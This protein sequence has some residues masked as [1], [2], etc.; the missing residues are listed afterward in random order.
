MA[1]A[2]LICGLTG[3]G[4]AIVRVDRCYVQ[5]W[6]VARQLLMLDQDVVL[7][8]GFDQ[9]ASRDR[10]RG[11]GGGGGANTV[12]H[13][14]A[15]PLEVRLERIRRRNLDGSERFAFEVNDDMVEF[16]DGRFEP[17]AD[18]ENVADG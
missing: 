10:F 15:A 9:R 4:K 12:V 3:A 5:I 14:A 1:T 16:M 7:D 2:H 13:L 18:D 17:P 11:L 8:L 6:S